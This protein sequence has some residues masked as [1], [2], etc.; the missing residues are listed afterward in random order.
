MMAAKEDMILDIRRQSP[1]DPHHPVVR[2]LAQGEM[3]AFTIA[4]SA[5][6]HAAEVRP[7]IVH[8][9]SSRFRKDLGSQVRKAQKEG[10]FKGQS[11]A[12]LGKAI[13]PFAD[14]DGFV[15]NVDDL[16]PLTLPQ[17]TMKQWLDLLDGL[18][19]LW[20]RALIGLGGVPQWRGAVVRAFKGFR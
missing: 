18:K 2:L 12:R 20:Q 3:L 16:R 5:N 15:C 1:A 14:S 13:R 7:W 9:S 17:D 6:L 4:D 10:P 11:K 19:C 8:G